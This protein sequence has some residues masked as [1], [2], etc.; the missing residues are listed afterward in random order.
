MCMCMRRRYG[1]PTPHRLTEPGPSRCNDPGEV[2]C[3]EATKIMTFCG[4]VVT[5]MMKCWRRAGLCPEPQ[6][7]SGALINN[8]TWAGWHGAGQLS[9]ARRWEGRQK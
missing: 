3:R 5:L 1:H 8:T 4:C 9:T 7:W 6:S 2:T